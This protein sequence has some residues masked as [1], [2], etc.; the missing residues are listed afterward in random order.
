MD[1]PSNCRFVQ[2][3]NCAVLLE[4]RINENRCNDDR[5]SSVVCAASGDKATSWTTLAT[6]EEIADRWR[7]TTTTKGAS[8]DDGEQKRRT[9]TNQTAI[10]RRWRRLIGKRGGLQ[11]CPNYSS[12]YA[13]EVLCLFALQLP[14]NT[15]H[16]KWK[17]FR[18]AHTMQQPPPQMQPQLPLAARRCCKRCERSCCRSTYHH[19]TY[20]STRRLGSSMMRRTTIN[21]H[22]LHRQQ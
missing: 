5:C 20:S 19:K 10:A 2:N 21:N 17:I 16:D 13:S 22:C 14:I 3:S 18:R 11:S 9:T 8:V 15:F 7:T 4:V 6:G 12:L 1:R